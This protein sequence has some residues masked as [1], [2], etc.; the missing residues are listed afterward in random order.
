MIRLVIN[1]RPMGQERA[2][3]AVRQTFGGKRSVVTYTP[4][5][6][7]AAV[8]EIR[9]VWIEAGQPVV[10]DGVPFSVRVTALM[11]RPVSHHRKDGT[12]TSAYREI[13]GT[14]DVDNILKLVLDAL[15]PV[16]FSD[17]RACVS[18]SVSKEYAGEDRL[19][20]EIDW[21]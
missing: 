14:Q 4:P 2:R 15:Q 3:H 10:P 21:A 20:V 11:R 1:A 16:C 19:L 18:A 5:R 9:A 7:R 8:S 12:R 17:D 13:P 6:T